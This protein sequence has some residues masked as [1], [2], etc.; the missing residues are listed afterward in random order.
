MLAYGLRLGLIILLFGMFITA[1]TVFLPEL[2]EPLVNAYLS[3]IV[4]MS[5]MGWLLPLATFKQI[6]VIGII[7]WSAIFAYDLWM[8]FFN[9][10]R[11][12]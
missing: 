2:P 11:S 7:F 6:I 3:I 12:S 5:Q 8:W 9:V 4:P 1:L 10:T